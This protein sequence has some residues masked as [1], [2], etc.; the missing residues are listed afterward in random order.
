L[1]AAATG[2]AIVPVGL[3]GTDEVQLPHER[4]PL[5]FRPVTV[6]LGPALRLGTG[7]GRSAVTRLRRTTDAI[8][9][10]I[11]ALSGAEYVDSYA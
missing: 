4:L 7:E 2:A 11:S 10:D 6:R 8:M 5:V 9:Q 1:T 3:I